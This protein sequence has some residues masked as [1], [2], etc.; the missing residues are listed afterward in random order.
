MIR[1]VLVVGWL[2]LALLLL[3]AAS[4]YQVAS[5]PTAQRHLVLA[6]FPTAALLFADLCVLVYVAGTR[7][8]VRRAAAELRLPADW[9]REQRRVAR[10]AALWP[11][12][13]VLA[14]AALFASGFAAYTASGYDSAPPVWAH[15]GLFVATALLE[16]LFLL[17]GGRS[18]RRCEAH[19]AAFGAAVE[20]AG[21]R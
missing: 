14:L 18:L 19:L 7:R 8:L 6:L 21:G 4:G 17:R 1:G 20:A 3:T 13:A 9:W 11:S 10:E 16:L 5:E 2:G 12:A 15:H